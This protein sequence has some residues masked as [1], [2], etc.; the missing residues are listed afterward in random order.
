MNSRDFSNWLPIQF[1]FRGEGTSVRW[2][3]FG[4]STLEEPFFNQTLR[5]LRTTKP[6]AAERTTDVSELYN[7]LL[8]TG[9][10]P[11]G[12]IFHVSRCGST[13]LLNALKTDRN[14][15]GLS[16]SAAIGPLLNAEVFW[17]S[18]MPRTMWE[19]TRRRLI[20]AVLESYAR[21]SSTKDAKIVIKC[22]AATILQIATARQ[23]WPSVPFVVVVR[24]PIDVIVS[25]VLV[26]AGWLR[27]RHIPIGRRNMFGW[28]SDEIEAMS[29]EEY[30][31]RG[32]G[33]FMEVARSC[34]D[35]RC[36]VIDYENLTPTTAL[37]IGALFGVSCAAD[38]F[39]SVWSLYSKD[40]SSTQRFEDDRNSKR[41]AATS[42]MREAAAEWATVP[43]ELLLS[44]PERDGHVGR[45]R[46]SYGVH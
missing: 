13:L 7:Q 8:A 16:E 24:N 6:P 37:R 18:G 9:Q 36:L 34:L 40:P 10:T 31:A 22:H 14:V 29:V 32:I 30:C 39:E 20:E 38:R 5:R 28:M 2:I 21:M 45:P 11:A 35:E 4:R 44:G 15:V 12:V 23:V 33:R 43:Y 27:A 25:N 3:D 19:S 1:T 41:R 26:P 46:T 17:N 42:A